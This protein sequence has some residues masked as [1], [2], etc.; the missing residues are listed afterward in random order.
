MMTSSEAGKSD[1]SG[2]L[3]MFIRKIYRPD[4]PMSL[5][6]LER[7]ILFPSLPYW[8]HKKGREKSARK[9]N[10]EGNGTHT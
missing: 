6:K 9:S 5:N 2:L 10:F 4:N 7:E 8:I 3:L 1:N